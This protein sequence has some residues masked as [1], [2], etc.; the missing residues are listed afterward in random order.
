[1][2]LEILLILLA[3]SF[4]VV[5]S[6]MGWWIGT[7]NKFRNAQQDINT[8]WS[9]IKTE[10]QRRADLFYNLVQAVKSYKNF[11]KDTLVKVTEART[12]FGKMASKM[13][14]MKKMKGL[15]AFFNKLMVTV[16]KYPN[17]KA[18]KQHDSLMKE[19]RITED[20]INVARTS[21]NDIVGSYNKMVTMF[22][23]SFVA[24][25]HNFKNE[26]F[27]VNEESSN[28]APKIDLG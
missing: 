13:A 5:I 20:R 24:S 1:M 7:Y 28:T 18:Y 8:M 16:E 17:L 9:D 3:I 26:E 12:G 23:S 2:I 15:D 22:P 19:I 4:F 6:T 11:E 27:Y 14:E 21:Y 10:Y 25:H